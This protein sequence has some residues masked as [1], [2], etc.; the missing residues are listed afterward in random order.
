MLVL[1]QNT[2]NRTK[3]QFHYYLLDLPKKQLLDFNC[4]FESYTYN[5][6]RKAIILKQ[7]LVFFHINSYM[8][9]FYLVTF[10]CERAGNAVRGGMKF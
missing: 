1:W 9:V 3:K 5:I 6:C 2:S 8:H 4:N 7:T 10:T